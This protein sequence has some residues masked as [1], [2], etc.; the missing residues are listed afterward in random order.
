MKCLPGLTNKDMT[1]KFLIDIINVC[2]EHR[3]NH[4]KIKTDLNEMIEFEKSLHGV[5]K[6]LKVDPF[7]EECDSITYSYNGIK[8]TLIL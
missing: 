6:M 1:E 2:A 3:V 7:I 4:L 5:Y 8:I